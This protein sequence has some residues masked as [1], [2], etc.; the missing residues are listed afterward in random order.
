MHRHHARRRDARCG[1]GA[2]DRPGPRP[3]C[4]RRSPARTLIVLA[5]SNPFLS[6]GPILAVPGMR[7]CA[8]RAAGAGRRRS[9]PSC[10]RGAAGTRRP[11]VPDRSA[12]SRPRRGSRA[13]YQERHPGLL[14][15]LVIDT[16]DADAGRADRRDRAWS[17]SVRRHR[18][19]RPRRPRAAARRPSWTGSVARPAAASRRLPCVGEPSRHR[20]GPARSGPSLDP[21]HAVVPLRT[22]AGGKARLGE[23]LDAEE[24]EELMLGMLAPDPRVLAGWTPC[25]RVHVVSPDRD[26]AAAG[27]GRR[28]CARHPPGDGEGLN[29]G[30]RAR[31]SPTRPRGGRRAVLILPADLPH[32]RAT[33][34]DRLLDAA[35]AALAAGSGRPLV[36]IAPSDARNGTN[37]PAAVPAGRHRA[38]ASGQPA[39]RRTCGPRPRPT[40]RSRWSPT[41]RSASTSTRPRT[42][43]CCRPALLRHCCAWARR[44]MA[45]TPGASGTAA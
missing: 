4:S 17:R 31:A 35:D 39:S 21:L 25:A 12:A 41:P 33:A 26:R 3:R 24:R 40:P 20:A 9:A 27:R 23:A 1:T 13:H 22:L 2:L 32:A 18:D 16:L 30:H 10:R 29:E 38:R 14:D 8:P 43:S 6:I 45:A 34:L 7:G 36:A 19:A 37:A 44:R 15:A 28:R 11:A 5:P 42:W